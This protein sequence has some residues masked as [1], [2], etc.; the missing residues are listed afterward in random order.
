VKMVLNGGQVWSHSFSIHFAHLML[1]YT[2][3][4][5]CACPP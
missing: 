2:S 3:G 1:W 4:L 5:L